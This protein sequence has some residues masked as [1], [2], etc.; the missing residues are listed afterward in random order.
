MCSPSILIVI[1]KEISFPN[2][3]L[4][5]TIATLYCL[6]PQAPLILTH[7]SNETVIA[8]RS[9]QLKCQINKDAQPTPT[10]EWTRD[11]EPLNIDRAF[12][13]L[14]EESCVLRINMVEMGDE[15][16]YTCTVTNKKGVASSSAKL[17]VMSPPDP[18]GKPVAK[19]LTSTSVSLSWAPPTFIGRS[20]VAMY[21]VECK[22]T[23]SD[24]CGY[25][26]NGCA[27]YY[28]LV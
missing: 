10:V 13:S 8:G 3:V 27:L 5:S 22:D 6:T 24:R 17:T 26:G 12:T 28:A 25:H 9:V 15:G 11:G 18:P 2:S 4:L 16:T 14:G 1:T 20:P 23:V 19:P 21:L 7:L